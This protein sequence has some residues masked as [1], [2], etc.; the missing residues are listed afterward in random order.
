M[1]PLRT[2]V[3]Y[4]C[5]D[6]PSGKP[7]RLTIARQLLEPATAPLLR[8][9]KYANLRYAYRWDRKFEYVI[10][11]HFGGVPNPLPNVLEPVQVGSFFSLLRVKGSVLG[12]PS[13]NLCPDVGRTN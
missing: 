9:R 5:I 2:K 7:L 8:Q 13:R 12:A 11:Y 4:S 6:T 1:Q 10:F 3:D